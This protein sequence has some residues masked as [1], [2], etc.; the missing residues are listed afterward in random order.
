MSDMV[1]V[2]ISPGGHYHAFRSCSGNGRPRETRK[3]TRNVTDLMAQYPVKTCR[4]LLASIKT[5]KKEQQ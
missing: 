4:C 3:V 2:W 5:H 1:A